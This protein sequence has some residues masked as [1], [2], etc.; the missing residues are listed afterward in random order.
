LGSQF[1]NLQ[2]TDLKIAT[3]SEFLIHSYAATVGVPVVFL[4]GDEGL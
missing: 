1:T 4:S 3:C 2:G